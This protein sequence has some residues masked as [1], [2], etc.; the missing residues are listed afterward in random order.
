M[1]Y[2]YEDAGTVAGLLVRALGAAVT[3]VFQHSQRLLH[4]LVAL[5]AVKMC[6][7]TD[8]TG[9]VFALCVVQSVM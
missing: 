3:H 6:H 7:H 5:A 1:G 4:Q 2:L 8:T 9:V